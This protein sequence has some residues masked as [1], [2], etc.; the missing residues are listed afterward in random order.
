MRTSLLVIF[1]CFG[2]SLSTAQREW[3]K[4]PSIPIMDMENVVYGPDDKIYLFPRHDKDHF[5]TSED[6]GISWDSIR[7]PTNFETVYFFSDGTPLFSHRSNYYIPSNS[8]GYQ[9]SEIILT[10]STV[11]IIEDTLYV[12]NNDKIIVS[13]DKGLTIANQYENPFP[14]PRW[15]PYILY[16]NEDLYYIIGKE[17]KVRDIIILDENFELVK[18][19]DN[20][21]IVTDIY[22]HNNKIQFF[23]DKAELH[24]CDM[25]FDSVIKEPAKTIQGYNFF[26]TGS[27]TYLNELYLFNRF[28]IFKHP[29]NNELTENWELISP[30]KGIYSDNFQFSNGKIIT[31]SNRLETA[32][33]IVHNINDIE[34]EPDTIFTTL[35]SLYLSEIFMLDDG[36][37]IANIGSRDFWLYDQNNNWLPTKI[38]S[39]VYGDPYSSGKIMDIRDDRLITYDIYTS[40]LKTTYYQSEFDGRSY[41]IDSTL[42][43]VESNNDRDT[44]ILNYSFDLGQ[45]F[46]EL[47]IS[48][49]YIDDIIDASKDNFL[50]IGEHASTDSTSLLK[51][52]NDNSFDFHDLRPTTSKN[53]REFITAI[54]PYCSDELNAFILL[55]DTVDNKIITQIQNSN[56]DDIN[57]NV[58]GQPF[59]SSL[60]FLDFYH[61]GPDRSYGQVDEK[62]ITLT[63]NYFTFTDTIPFTVNTNNELNSRCFI[64][65]ESDIFVA[66]DNGQ[67]YML[68]SGVLD[69]N[70]TEISCEWSAENQ[71]SK[72]LWNFSDTE[73]ISHYSILRK[74]PNDS[75]YEEIDQV[76]N[77]TKTSNVY[78]DNDIGSDGVYYYKVIAHNFNG[79]TYM[80]KVVSCNI[81]LQTNIEY[82]IKSIYPNPA[83]ENI[84]ITLLSDIDQNIE[85][86]ICN[87]N[88]QSLI[89]IRDYL[90][91][92]KQKSI[93][94]E[95]ADLTNGTYMLLL[96]TKENS[97][98]KKIIITQ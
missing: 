16:K 59:E 26:I 36:N 14:M 29:L 6:S 70:K 46:E 68:K 51:V 58:V 19:L 55:I 97:I 66:D 41:L 28:R 63:Y 47:I 98:I 73:N 48:D 74:T 54:L 86:E 85:V 40:E 35:S 24:T 42:V 37:I 25:L 30:N 23:N 52:N 11:T 31:E 78:Y 10:N 81:N 89:K 45:S 92:D 9:I 61:C 72:L 94:I 39:S 20:V 71:A 43:F 34:K 4:L 50:F 82:L 64:H 57:F 93:Q 2:L 79:T 75:Y 15:E 91:K 12:I 80:S 49:F 87:L 38:E 13:Y 60:F 33:W 27:F 62:F 77:N 65:N 5:Y 69:I 44:L 67:L 83:S 88:G 32:S 21:E 76:N 17:G 8:N 3:E 1:L 53:T 90:L 18:F 7:Q 96:K 22:F 95:T 56:R 84:S